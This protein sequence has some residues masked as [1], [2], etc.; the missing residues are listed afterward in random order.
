MEGYS[1]SPTSTTP[2]LLTYDIQENSRLIVASSFEELIRAADD[3][4]VLPFEVNLPYPR[5]GTANHQS[6]SAYCQEHFGPDAIPNSAADT[7]WSPQTAWVMH[8]DRR[9]TWMDTSTFQFADEEDA[10]AFLLFAS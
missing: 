1:T 2:S 4:K 6:L 10:V 7:T 3:A 9:W 8:R 5:A